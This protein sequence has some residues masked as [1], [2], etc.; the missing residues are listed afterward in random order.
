MSQSNS[1]DLASDLRSYVGGGRRDSK[2]ESDLLRRLRALP[3]QE[4][5]ALL[6]PLLELKKRSIL[7][8]IHRAQLSRSDYL[9]VL[10]R[11]L[12]EVKNEPIQFWMD[13][14]VPHIGWRKTFSVLRESMATNP[15]AGAMALYSVPWVCRGKG[16]LSGSLA[17][18]ELT[19]ECLRLIV[20]YHDNGHRVIDDRTVEKFKRAL[21][22][23]NFHKHDSGGCVVVEFKLSWEDWQES[24][25]IRETGKRILDQYKS[26]Y[27]SFG[28]ETRRFTANDFGWTYENSSGT[29]RYEWKQLFGVAHYKRVIMLMATEC[30]YPLSRS[31][32]DEAQ[33][34]Q[35]ML[36]LERAMAGH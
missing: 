2:K 25:Q 6:L 5:R 14:T 36:W 15:R 23:D 22:D 24:R 29:A 35:L 3:Q 31:A 19:L 18:S 12:N 21:W 16:Q 30:H 26:D 7:E 13:A 1:S 33:L 27:L 10:K 17:T 32:F 11:G 28:A 4:R 8:L 20:E 34:A 9:E